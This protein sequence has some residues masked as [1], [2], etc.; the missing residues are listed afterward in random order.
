MELYIGNSF[1]ISFIQRFVIVNLLLLSKVNAFEN[2]ELS[3]DSYNDLRQQ[4]WQDITNQTREAGILF[5]PYTK[6]DS[7]I[8]IKCDLR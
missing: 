1:R 6:I 4:D 8:S 2:Q 7:D 3:L 5:H